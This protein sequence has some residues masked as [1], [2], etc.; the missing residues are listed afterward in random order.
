MC[1]TKKPKETDAIKQK[2]EHYA[3]FQRRID[4][5]IERLE[6]LESVIGSPSGP[7]L[8]G[9]PGGGDDGTSKTERQV[10]KKLELQQT[11]RDMIAAEAAE[12]KEL[13]AMIEQM[14]SPDE[15]TVIEMRYFDHA[16][17]WP[18]CAALF[19]EETDYEEKADKYLK[20]TF[21]I[22][23][24][25]LQALAKIYKQ[26]EGGQESSPKAIKRPEAGHLIH[27]AGQ[28]CEKLR[29]QKGIKGDKKGLKEIT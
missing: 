20:R 2:L 14:R 17:W 11:I 18:V 10:L 3:A 29:G 9:L 15:Q 8:T 24:S 23:G 13:E 21:K 28:H 25:A 27:T 6:Y 12:H 7:N 22:H 19:G 1:Q 26:R 5:Q 16:K 4:N